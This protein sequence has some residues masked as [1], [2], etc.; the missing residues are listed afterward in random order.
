V[1]AVDSPER[2][3]LRATVRRFAERE[4][5]PH[6]AAWAMTAARPAVLS[7]VSFALSGQLQL[8]T[9]R[10]TDHCAGGSR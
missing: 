6:Q 3:E 7:V 10:E 1:S 9:E 8:T 2:A 5:Q 4:V